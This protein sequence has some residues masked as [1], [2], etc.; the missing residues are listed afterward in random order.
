MRQ[1]KIKDIEEKIVEYRDLI[2]E[3]PVSHKGSWREVFAPDSEDKGLFVEIGCG[4]GRFILESAKNS[5]EDYFIA[6]EGFSSVI[7]R[8]LQKIRSAKVENVRFILEFVLDLGTWFAD[9]E[10]DGLY[11]N[12]SDPWPKKRNAKRRLTYRDRLEQ[13]AKALKPGG[14]LRIKTD[15][16]DFFEF[17]LEELEACKDRCGYTVEFMT[18][19]L[20]SSEW[21][22]SSPMTEYEMKFAE[23]GKNINF[24]ALRKI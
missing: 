11:L 4:K 20:H 7:Y 23:T 14:I 1:R 16:D 5:P 21:A 13:Y 3:E 9:E 2:V 15:N 18:Y 24:L 17:T 12:F 22:T 19:D 8:A 6:V 10:I